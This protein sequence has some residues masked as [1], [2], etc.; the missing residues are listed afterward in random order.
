MALPAPPTAEEVLDMVRAALAAPAS[1]HSGLRS[2]LDH[3]RELQRRFR[4]EPVGGRLVA[5]KKLVYW[6]AASS[7]DRQAK[8]VEALLDA[9]EELVDEAERAAAAPPRHGE[10]RP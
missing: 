5:L 6:F 4:A 7:F 1:G 2:R 10:E 8:A 3:A 9:V